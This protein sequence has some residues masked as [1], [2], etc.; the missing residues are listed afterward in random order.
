M[1]QKL[2]TRMCMETWMVNWSSMLPLE[3]WEWAKEPRETSHILV[4][5]GA[6][7]LPEG[8]QAH[9]FASI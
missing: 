2:A 8:S 5:F 3:V 7:E 6:H 1:D 9:D 4:Y